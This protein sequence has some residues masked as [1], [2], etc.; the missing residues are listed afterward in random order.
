MRV[1]EGLVKAC[2]CVRPGKVVSVG[3]KDKSSTVL[4]G[5]SGNGEKVSKGGKKLQVQG[6]CVYWGV[7]ELGWER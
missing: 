7:Q 6:V 2:L 5:V 3:V 4:V 1:L